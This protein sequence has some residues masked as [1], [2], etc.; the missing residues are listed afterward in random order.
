MNDQTHATTAEAIFNI[1]AV[2]RMTGIPITTRTPGNAATASRIPRRARWAATAC[3]P[4][5][6]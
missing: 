4:R 1:G 5:K 3:I 6:M 2:T